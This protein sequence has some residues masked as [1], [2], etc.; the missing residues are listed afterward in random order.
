MNGQKLALKSDGPLAIGAVLVDS[1]EVVQ[2]LG[3]HRGPGELAYVYLGHQREVDR[4]VLIRVLE[5]PFDPFEGSQAQKRFLREAR[6][7][8]SVFHPDVVKLYDLGLTDKNLPYTITEWL[9]GQS[10]A[11]TLAHEGPLAV[12]RAI[13][14]F[15]RCLEVLGQAHEAGIVHRDLNPESLSLSHP[16][17]PWERLRIP[18]FALAFL[19]D[20]D[21]GRVTKAGEFIGQPRYLS[22]EYLHHGL[23]SPSLDVYQM[24]LVLV[25]ALTG[26]P[27]VAGANH[28]EC[29]RAHV[30]GALDVPI[31]LRQGSLGPVLARALA[32][33]PAER[34]ENGHAFASALWDV[35]PASAI[36]PRAEPRQVAPTEVGALLDGQF[37]LRSELGSGGCA[38]VY[39]G[40]HIG[41]GQEIA[42]KI[43][44]RRPDPQRHKEFVTRFAREGE[45]ARRLRHP[46]LA[47]VYHCGVT[48]DGLPY[49]VMERLR[50]HDLER[51]L[52]ESGPMDPLRA[53]PMFSS[54]LDALSVAH[55]QGVV[56]KDLKP[57]NLFIHSPELGRELLKIV[58]FGVARMGQEEEA[59]LTQTGQPVCTPGYAAPEY[60]T[61]LRATPALD[62][63]QMGLILTEALTGKALVSS[64]NALTCI[65]AHV[66]GDLSLPPGLMAGP[67]GPVLKK[68]LALK[69]EDRYPDGEAFAR[70]LRQIDPRVALGRQAAP[71]DRAVKADHADLNCARAFVTA[72]S[73]SQKSPHDAERLEP[74]LRTCVRFGQWKGD[75]KEWGQ[76]RAM[77][78]AATA[79]SRQRGDEPA[80]RRLESL[81]QELENRLRHLGRA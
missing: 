29:V 75:G 56:H 35:D 52:A 72:L 57:S 20:G 30:T 2:L 10:L 22:P 65:M 34:F 39:E 3:Y 73:V 80:A 54:C 59:R 4:N 61:E 68:A 48:P 77:V 67:L 16:G 78:S 64:T 36:A 44:R 70:A 79:A 69:P 9:P 47:A 46:N 27:A 66:K 55:K 1:Y 71:V 5:S 81:G 19:K 37:E 50:G 32:L 40:R 7:V 74:L 23:I 26:R 45:V 41:S 24:G 8:S 17:M 43:M 76:L 58:D 49:L 6:A 21:G 62:V 51:E 15:A 25:E 63:Y 31:E 33:N 18:S 28:V 38:V 53:L 13:R 12:G 60:L 11:A 42:I 14:L